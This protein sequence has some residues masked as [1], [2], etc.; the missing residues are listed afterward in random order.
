[1]PL[2]ILLP[3]SSDY[4]E[5]SPYPYRFLVS[6]EPSRT[7]QKGNLIASEYKTKEPLFR[8]RM[9]KGEEIVAEETSNNTIVFDNLTLSFTEPTF[10]IQLEA[11]KDPAYP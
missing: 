2:M 3:G 10:W 9:F 6:L 4:F 5:V 8:V 11:V 1:M 7:F